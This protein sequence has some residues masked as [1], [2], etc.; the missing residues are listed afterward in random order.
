VA[1]KLTARGDPQGVTLVRLFGALSAALSLVGIAPGRQL[2]HVA[3]TPVW[4]EPRKRSL[5][6]HYA[7]VIRLL[8][9]VSVL[10]ACT[11]ACVA[12][13]GDDDGLATDGPAAEAYVILR[14][15]PNATDALGFDDGKIVVSSSGFAERMTIRTSRPI[16]L[17]PPGDPRDLGG[18]EIGLTGEFGAP[19]LVIVNYFIADGQLVTIQIEGFDEQ[20]VTEVIGALEPA[21]RDEWAAWLSQR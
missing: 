16:S 9:A 19:E 4:S 20:T 10:I 3:P 6:G 13:G 17:S 18:R 5:S 1:D 14:D 12:C 11:I 15:E 8:R 7:L 21:T 2:A